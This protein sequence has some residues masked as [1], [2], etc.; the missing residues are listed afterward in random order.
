MKRILFTTLAIV[1]SA[2]ISASAIAQTTASETQRNIN[3]QTRIEEG[4]KSGELNTREAARLE[5]QQSK[6]NRDQARALQ[7]GKLTAEEK[8]KI[9]AEQNKVSQNIKQEKSD[10]QKGNPNSA[11]SQRVQ[12]DVQR[13]INQQERIKAGVKSGELTKK[14]TAKLQ[15]GQARVEHK[16]SVAGRDGHVGAREE[17]KIQ[18]AEND[19]SKKI[20]KQKHDAQVKN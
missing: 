15:R 2:A 6:V 5:Q 9:Q 13:N 12:A 1:V 10:A 17:V 4:L 20:Y 18:S 11:S 3:Q 16:Q 7:D 19:Q 8:A 14:E